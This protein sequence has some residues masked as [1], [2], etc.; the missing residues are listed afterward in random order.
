MARET[1]RPGAR[2]VFV[3]CGLC[4]VGVAVLLGLRTDND[5]TSLAALLGGVLLILAAGAGRLPAEIGL[6]RVTFEDDDAEPGPDYRKDLYDAVRAALPDGGGPE[7]APEWQP[8]QPIYWVHEL[9]LRVVV[10]WAPDESWRI[11]AKVVKPLAEKA[12]PDGG[13]LMI[14]NSDDVEELETAL[15]AVLGERAAVIRWRSPADNDALHRTVHKL[16]AARTNQ[17]RRLL[18]TRKLLAGH[19]LPPL[20]RTP[21]RRSSGGQGKRRPSDPDRP[22]R[23]V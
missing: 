8:E 16:R 5:M 11:D 6:Q 7:R 17:V 22:G 15:R 18:K 19:R 2:A 4:L 10:S 12:G 14:T 21:R 23:I 13:V 20:R 9:R 3:V 1:L